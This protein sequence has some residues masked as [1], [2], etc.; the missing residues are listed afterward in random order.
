MKTIYSSCVWKKRYQKPYK[1][2]KTH[3]RVLIFLILLMISTIISW[4][5]FLDNYADNMVAVY[6][7]GG[8]VREPHLAQD[9]K[10]WLNLW[11]NQELL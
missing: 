11:F 3:W 4:L 6:P 5:L 7:Q 9:T 1:K 10:E 8:W 2:P